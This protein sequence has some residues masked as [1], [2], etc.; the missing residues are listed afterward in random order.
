MGCT[1]GCLDFLDTN[2]AQHGS[3]TGLICLLSAYMNISEFTNL[4]EEVVRTCVREE[5]ELK[6]SV[7]YREVEMR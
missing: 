1:L 2:I 3:C 5:K 7:Y 6:R 4:R